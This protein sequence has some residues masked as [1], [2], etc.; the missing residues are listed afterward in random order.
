MKKA[1]PDAQKTQSDFYRQLRE[2]RIGPLYLFEGSELF[3]RREALERLKEAA[4]EAALLDFNYGEIA[5]TQ[6]NLDEA[7]AQARQYPMI[8]PRRMLVVTGFE[9]ISDEA[10][11]DQLKD[12]VRSPVAT[13]VLVFVTDGLDNRRNIATILRKSCELVSFASFDDRQTAQWVRDYAARSGCTI[14]PGAASHLVA[15]VGVNL[16]RLAVEVD[17][18]IN[19]VSEAGSEAV[20]TGGRGVAARRAITERDIDQIVRHSREHSNFELTD[21]I[22]AGDRRRALVLLDRIYANSDESAQSLSLM[23]LGAIAG[24]YRRMLIA[25]D[26]MAR[27]VPNSEIAQAVGMSPYAVTYLNEKARRFDISRLLR[28]IG[29]VA[30]VDLALKT[31]LGTPRMQMEILVSQLAGDRNG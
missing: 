30:R 24:N 18:L 11:I 3:L 1:A 12:Y 27:N 14:D 23:I 19:Y 8:S 4:L 10:V 15:T 28:G 6:G 22:I 9:A 31:S 7:L 17:K 25:R 13:T 20:A 16:V 5:V 21:A 26:L 29:L 2:G